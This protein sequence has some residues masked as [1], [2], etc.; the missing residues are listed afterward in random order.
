VPFEEEFKVNLTE[1]FRIDTGN[2]KSRYTFNILGEEIPLYFKDEVEFKNY[3]SED[4][5]IYPSVFGFYLP[6][7]FKKT[8]F[9]EYKVEQRDLSVDEAKK[10][11]FEDYENYKRKVNGEIETEYIKEKIENGAYYLCVD[12]TVKI[13]IAE[14]KAVEIEY[15]KTEALN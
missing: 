7:S 10:K 8:L 4:S 5:E 13:D 9:V 1:S 6:F 14:E 12:G 3:Y 15:K 2:L 11:A